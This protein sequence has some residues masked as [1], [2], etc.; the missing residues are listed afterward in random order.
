MFSNV[1]MEIINAQGDQFH[2]CIRAATND[3]S[4]SR[5]VIDY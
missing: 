2:V 1:H 5:L 4:D 3:Y